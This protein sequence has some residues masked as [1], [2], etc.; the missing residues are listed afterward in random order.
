MTV[1]DTND[2]D[3]AVKPEFMEVIK[4]WTRTHNGEVVHEF[5]MP[6]DGEDIIEAVQWMVA[7]YDDVECE[8]GEEWG[9]AYCHLIGTVRSEQS[10]T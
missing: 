1:S 7:V 5:L 4:E 8:Y 2:I 9:C 3:C 10:S 6:E